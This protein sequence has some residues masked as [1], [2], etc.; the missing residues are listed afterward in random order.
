MGFTIM[1]QQ[2]R[3]VPRIVCDRC[4]EFIEEDGIVMYQADVNTGDAVTSLL[5]LHARQGEP[6]CNTLYEREHPAPEGRTWLTE[7]A[8]IFIA[9]MAHNARIDLKKAS[10]IGGLTS[11]L[12]P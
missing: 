5:T 11:G 7:M 3:Y 4:G 6:N 2:G 12:I 8:S 9:N 10:E 1:H